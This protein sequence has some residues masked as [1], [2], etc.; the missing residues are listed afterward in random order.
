[1][2]E[3]MHDGM[4]VTAEACEVVKVE[5]YARV[6]D[7]A[8]REMHDVVYDDGR[9]HATERHA[10]L[11]EVVVSPQRLL[12]HVLPRLGVVQAV[13]ELTRHASSASAL[14]ARHALARHASTVL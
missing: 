9:R 13:G 12:A 7:V 10:P 4:A 5:R 8:W 6:I 14:T 11:A 1:M 2:I 3:A